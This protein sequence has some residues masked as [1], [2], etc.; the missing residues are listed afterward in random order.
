MQNSGHEGSLPYS[1]PPTHVRPEMMPRTSQ[2]ATNHDPISGTAAII[3]GIPNPIS[4]P[5]IAVRDAEPNP[6]P[7]IHRCEHLARN[8]ASDLSPP[9]WASGETVPMTP[10][11]L[12]QNFKNRMPI[13]TAISTDVSASMGT[14]S[15]EQSSR[16]SSFATPC[17][18]IRRQ[19]LRDSLSTPL[20]RQANCIADMHSA[21]DGVTTRGMTTV[22][23]R[24][25]EKRPPRMRFELTLSP[26]ITNHALAANSL[27]YILHLTCGKTI[28]AEGRAGGSWKCP[29]GKYETFCTEGQ[30]MVH[31]HKIFVPNLPLL[32]VEDRHHLRTLDEAL[33]KPSGSSVYVKWDT[34]L[35][36]KRNKIP[37]APPSAA[38]DV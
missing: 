3:T 10:S 17:S 31:V 35:L 30:Q 36:W 15:N 4:P 26:R 9:S 32:H 33:V 18:N 14:T 28:V 24:T 20:Q 22:A 19:D 23:D 38:E 21:P 2:P 29:S 1:L 11:T 37:R 25:T 27:C 12:L 6:P 34:R 8:Q 7:P 13:G 16:P 5:P